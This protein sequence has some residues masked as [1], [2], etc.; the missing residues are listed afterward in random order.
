MQGG[1]AILSHLSVS[2]FQLFIIWGSTDRRTFMQSLPF[3]IVA[4]QI[5]SVDFQPSDRSILVL[6]CGSLRL[7]K[8]ASPIKYSQSFVLV[9][10]AAGSWYVQ[11]G[12]RFS[13]ATVSTLLLKFHADLIHEQRYFDCTMAD[14]CSASGLSLPRS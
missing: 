5:A 12:E 3:Q 4:H 7:D 11:N 2:S 6:V 1:T 10:A 9:Q 13:R 8:A 14:Q